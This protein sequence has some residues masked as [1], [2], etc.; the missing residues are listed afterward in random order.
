MDD[1]CGKIDQGQSTLLVTLD[2]SVA[3]D[4]VEH[5]VLLTRLERS[6]G[7]RRVFAPLVA[8]LAANLSFT[9]GCFPDRYK[10][11]PVTPLMKHPGLDADNPTNSYLQP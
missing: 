1:L 9:E 6:F 3:F 2:L 5:S 4:A 10:R 11:A 8:H 7:V